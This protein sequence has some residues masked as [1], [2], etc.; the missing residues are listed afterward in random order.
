MAWNTRTNWA[1]GQVPSAAEMNAPGL[2]A[3]TWGGNVNGGGYALSNVMLPQ[4][5]WVELTMLNSWVAYSGSNPVPAAVKD[6]MGFV[7][8]RGAMKS[9]TYTGGTTLFT[10]PVGMRPLLAEVLPL[11]VPGEASSPPLLVIETSGA[12]KVYSLTGNSYLY[13][14]GSFSTF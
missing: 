14:A 8:L 12:C 2:D 7:H 9:G 13:L 11:V 5:A 10:L 6:M 3:R 4:S 1:T